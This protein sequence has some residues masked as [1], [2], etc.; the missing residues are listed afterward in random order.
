MI[1]RHVFV[2]SV[3]LICCG[4]KLALDFKVKKTRTKKGKENRFLTQRFADLAWVKLSWPLNFNAKE[5]KIK[6]RGVGGYISNV[7]FR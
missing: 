7:T 2:R 5:N 1:E 3:S 4:F 6:K